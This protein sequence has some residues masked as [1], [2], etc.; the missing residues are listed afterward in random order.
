MVGEKM[1]Q[2]SADC[3]QYVQEECDEIS[4][5]IGGNAEKLEE[6]GESIK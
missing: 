5:K 6:E 4:K 3:T 1:R 2:L